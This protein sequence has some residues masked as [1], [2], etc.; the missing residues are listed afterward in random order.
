MPI[1]KYGGSPVEEGLLFEQSANGEIQGIESPNRMDEAINQFKNE[2]NNRTGGGV[3]VVVHDW[4][5]DRDTG[6][7]GDSLPRE[8][9]AGR[10]QNPPDHDW[11]KSMESFRR[12]LLSVHRSMPQEIQPRRVKVCRTCS[13]RPHTWLLLL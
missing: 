7:R 9:A 11:V 10:S 3:K 4:A 5:A 8:S 2:I 13:R 12:S 1:L 6:L